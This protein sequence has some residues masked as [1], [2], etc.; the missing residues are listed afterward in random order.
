MLSKWTHLDIKPRICDNHYCLKK[1]KEKNTIIL[2]YKYTMY[3]NKKTVF[4]KYMDRRWNSWIQ[5]NSEF[6]EMD[7]KFYTVYS[8]LLSMLSIFDNMN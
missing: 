3:N 8:I 6:G 4:Y 5:R 1:K 2:Y 7:N